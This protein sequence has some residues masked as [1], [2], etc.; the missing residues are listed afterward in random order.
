MHRTRQ[1]RGER[2]ASVAPALGFLK[3]KF[4]LE[5]NEILTITLNTLKS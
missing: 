1:G 3:M 5:I 2:G 4:K